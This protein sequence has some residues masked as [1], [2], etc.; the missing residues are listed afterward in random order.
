MEAEREIYIQLHEASY[1]GHYGGEEGAAESCVRRN[2]G[3]P[4]DVTPRLT[5]KTLVIVIYVIVLVTDSVIGLPVSDNLEADA[6]VS[7]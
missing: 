2:R 7:N 1:C 5:M 6:V 3:H 4:R